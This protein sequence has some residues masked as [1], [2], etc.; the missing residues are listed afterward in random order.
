MGVFLVR[1]ALSTVPLLVAILVASF[2]FMRLAPGGPFDD[3]RSLDPQVRANL[4]A[5]YGLDR[6]LPEQ[7]WLYSSGL[8]H[9]DLGPS[10]KYTG[11]TVR[12]I[13][14]QALPVSLTLGV[15]AL[16]LA[17]LTGIPLGVVG[18]LHHRRWPDLLATALSLFGICVPNF[19]LG[20]LLILLFV[21]ALHWLPLGG[22][23]SFSQL[24]LPAITLG[25]VRAAY[26]ARLARAGT[27]EVLDQDFVRTARAKG[28][29]ERD[30]LGRH[31]LRLALLPVVSYLGPAT[32]SILVGS[33]VVE[34][35]FAIPGLGTFFVNAAL[36]R[37][38]TL[39]MGTV[40]LYSGLLIAL[41]TLVDVL[42]HVLDPRQE[43]S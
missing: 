29:P 4:E 25:A 21:F 39:A 30:V 10:F 19:V 14:G 22:Y 31:T 35:I 38:Y 13:L 12:E 11:W 32:A 16:L 18:A 5:R 17:L 1:R 37:D 43:L 42:Y 15:A 27:L 40:L 6:S 36:N 9:G 8:L 23:G 28:L 7:F 26:V 34:K 24:I 2:F 33:V 3:E 20:P 41:N